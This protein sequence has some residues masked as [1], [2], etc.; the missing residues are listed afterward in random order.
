MNAR[1]IAAT[2]TLCLIMCL[3]LAWFADTADAGN[4]EIM[5]K[6]GIGGLFAGKGLDSDKAPSKVKKWLGI[7]SIFVMIAVVKYL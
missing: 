1:K 2:F 6:K 3:M 4:N 7:G 5:E